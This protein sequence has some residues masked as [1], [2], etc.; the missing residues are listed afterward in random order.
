MS[1]CWLL[2]LTT[3][4]STNEPGSTY[5]IN[6]YNANLDAAP[7]SVTTAAQKACED[8]KMNNI[9]GNGTKVD[10]HVTAQTADGRTVTINI[11]QAGDNVSKMSVQVGDTGDQAISQ[12]IVD[13]TKSH[14]SWF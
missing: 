2:T 11:E 8:L 1:L 10:G 3:G 9:V 7:D 14:L 4:C 13:R 6:T 12:Q 5:T